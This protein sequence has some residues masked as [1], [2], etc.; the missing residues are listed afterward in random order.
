MQCTDFFV[1]KFC[2]IHFMLYFDMYIM[3]IFSGI[4]LN[5]FVIPKNAFLSFQFCYIGSKNKIAKGRVQKKKK[6]KVGF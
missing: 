6:K 1:F 4:K 3:G 2:P 5:I